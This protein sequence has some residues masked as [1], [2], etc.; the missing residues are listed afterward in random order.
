MTHV[1]VLSKAFGP[2][3]QGGPN[4]TGV[5]GAVA[6]SVPITNQHHTPG[7]GLCHVPVP[8]PGALRVLSLMLLMTL[9]GR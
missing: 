1:Q 8:V 7:V 4:V 9:C 2:R 6:D 5:R 3:G